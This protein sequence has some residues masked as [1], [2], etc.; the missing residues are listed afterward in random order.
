MPTYSTSS[1]VVRQYAFPDHKV[2][3]TG[4]TAYR[5]LARTSDAMK[6]NGIPREVVFWHGTDGK[7]V[8]TCPLGG[9]D[10][11][12]TARIKEPGGQERASWGRDVSVSHFIDN[13]R[14]FCPPV[15]QLLG[16]V[17]Y[18]QQFDYFAGPR[19]DTAVSSDGLAVLVG[20]ASHPLSGAFG[21]GAGF[22]LEDAYVLGGAIEWAVSAERPL[23]DALKLFDDVRTPHYN[24]LYS[25]LDGFAAAD[26]QLLRRG[27]KPDEE[28]EARI[29]A[30]WGQKHQWMYYYKVSVCD[31]MHIGKPSNTSVSRLKRRSWRL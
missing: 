17:T 27:L 31:M 29:E 24:A 6:I 25:V 1:Q 16:L 2:A 15:W 23:A 3:Y 4:A 26:A 21:A 11:E 22:A 7:W 18:V 9:D 28:I 19:L 30:L 10:I 14:E 12:I 8:Y 20:D 13:F 5:T